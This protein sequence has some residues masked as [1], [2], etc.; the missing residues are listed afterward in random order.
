MEPG[1]D[2]F[3]SYTWA[4]R[5]AVQSLAQE[6]RDHGL[7]VFVDDPEIEDFTRITTTI[8]HTWLHPRHCWPTTRPPIPLGGR[9]S[10]S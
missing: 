2:V 9:A 7:R 3:V 4:D 6:L 10:G 8:T 5:A 1:Y